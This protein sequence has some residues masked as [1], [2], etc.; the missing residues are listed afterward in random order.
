MGFDGTTGFLPS[1]WLI[2]YKPLYVYD[3]STYAWYKFIIIIHDI[4]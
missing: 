2:L 1:V 4:L 3:I